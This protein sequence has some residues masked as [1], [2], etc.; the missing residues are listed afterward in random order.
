MGTA[1]VMAKPAVLLLRTAVVPTWMTASRSRR[2]GMLQLT[3]RV[4][5]IAASRSVTPAAAAAK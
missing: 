2:H 1:A 4:L 3:A 5:A